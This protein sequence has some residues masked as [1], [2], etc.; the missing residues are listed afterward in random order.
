ME[1]R[2]SKKAGGRALCFR[3][4]HLRGEAEGSA[5]HR[6]LT[7]VFWPDLRLIAAKI[8]RISLLTLRPRTRTRLLRLRQTRQHGDD[9]HEKVATAGKRRII[10]QMSRLS[11]L[12][13]SPAAR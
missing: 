2:R 12:L 8:T 10:R 4:Y 7:S 11:L 6:D 5:G 3:S 1:K 13:N 9:P